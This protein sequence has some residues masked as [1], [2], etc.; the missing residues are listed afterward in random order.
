ML[1]SPKSSSSD[2]HSRACHKISAGLVGEFFRGDSGHCTLLPA[3]PADRTSGRRLFCSRRLLF[4]H[5]LI[6]LISRRLLIFLTLLIIWRLLVFLIFRQLLFVRRLPVGGRRVI[7]VGRSRVGLSAWR[8]AVW[9]AGLSARGRP[10]GVAAQHV[11]Q[12]AVRVVP[13]VVVLR[14]RR[15]PDTSVSA[16]G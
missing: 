12:A 5:L 2:R 10:R 13:V 6:F 4:R 7:R 8:R 15:K 14:S 3:L 9:G 11:F 16:T 1:T